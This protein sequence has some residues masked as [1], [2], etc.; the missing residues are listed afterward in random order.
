MSYINDLKQKETKLVNLEAKILAKQ[1]SVKEM[2]DK[3]KK[4]EEEV[5]S[6]FGITLSQVPEELEKS[7]Q[8]FNQLS[9]QLENSIKELENDF[10]KINC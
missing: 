5:M 8:K 7:K 4:A 10:S 1:Q 6:K 9:G 2:L 3:K